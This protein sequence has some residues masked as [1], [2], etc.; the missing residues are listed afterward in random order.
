[1]E[2]VLND[3]LEEFPDTGMSLIAGKEG[4][5]R[6]VSWVHITETTYMADFLKGGEFIL[7]TGVGIHS[8]DDFLKF[9]TAL[10]RHQAAGLCV[11]TGD[12][13]PHLPQEVLDFCDSRRFPL[14]TLP[15]EVSFESL[16]RPMSMF[17]MEQTYRSDSLT[18][19]LQAVI[20]HPAQAE[21]FLP[22]LEKNG[23]KEG[24]GCVVFVL[25]ADETKEES[26]EMLLRACAH[27][28]RDMPGLYCVLEI[29]SYP[30]AVLMLPEGGAKSLR[31]AADKLAAAATS[32]LPEGAPLYLAAGHPV[33]HVQELGRCFHQARAVCRLQKSGSIP[34][35]S[36]LM[37]DLGIWRL[38][39]EVP[40]ESVLREYCDSLLA[41]LLSYDRE[42]G[43]A[44]ARVLKEYLSQDG[45]VAKTAEHFYVHRNTVTYQLHKAEEILCVNLS[46]L[47]VRS[48]LLAAFCAQELLSGGKK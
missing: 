37:E 47:K 27:A 29:A 16:I 40:N 35:S 42:H 43:T 33:T 15:R 28:L 32:A 48:E 38:L 34:S 39:L 9:L 1:M 26:R 10:I 17:L 30:A 3:L 41:P 6:R 8:T 7:A 18:A 13:M 24:S 19:A 4:L 23:W 25:S 44:L 21:S 45:S 46:S 11:D 12:Y 5:S 31:S 14:F 20:T 2:I 36:R 22:V